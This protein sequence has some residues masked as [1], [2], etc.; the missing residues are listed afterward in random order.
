MIKRLLTVLIYFTFLGNILITA[1]DKVLLVSDACYN[2][3]QFK[4]FSSCLYLLEED[5]TARD[6]SL[7]KED[8]V[9]DYTQ[10]VEMTLN[11]QNT[12][13]W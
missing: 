2:K 10:F 6:I 8:I 5:T 4:Q 7:N 13:T 9:I 11:A 1:Q 12:I 3:M